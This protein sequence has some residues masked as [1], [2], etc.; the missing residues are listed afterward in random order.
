L[1]APSNHRLARSRTGVEQRLIE[2]LVPHGWEPVVLGTQWEPLLSLKVGD[3]YF[4]LTL[5]EEGD[6]G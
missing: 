2:A 5:R 1:T 4:D 6:D 3:T